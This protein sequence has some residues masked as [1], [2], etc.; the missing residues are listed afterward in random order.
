M[1]ASLSPS[2]S[3]TCVVS[4]TRWLLVV[5]SAAIWFCAADH[6][7]VARA[8][9]ERRDLPGCRLG[10]AGPGGGRDE[11]PDAQPSPLGNTATQLGVLELLGVAGGL[12]HRVGTAD[13]VPD[14]HVRAVLAG[15]DEQR[16]QIRGGLQ[17]V[18]GVRRVVGPALSRAV[19]RADPGGVGD[20]R[21]DVAPGR[22]ELTQPALQNDGRAARAGAVQVEPCGA[23]TDLSGRD[24]PGRPRE[25]RPVRSPRPAATNT[26]TDVT[27]VSTTMMF[28]RPSAI[29]KPM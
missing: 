12:G 3:A 16:V 9:L 11:L 10:E 7:G 27:I 18:R 25:A 29:A 13:R 14:E 1:P 20:G 15:P 6:P 22:G 24:R 2:S 17:A 19:V 4:A 5:D 23:A 21:C 28:G 8:A 26:K